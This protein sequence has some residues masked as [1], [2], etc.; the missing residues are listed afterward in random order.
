STRIKV[1]LIDDEFKVIAAG[2]SEWENELNAD[3]FWTYSENIIWSKLQEA[4][5]NLLANV[6]R[7]FECIPTGYGAVG[8]SAMMHGY[9][10]LDKSGKLLVPFRTWRNGNTDQATKELSKLFNFNIPHRWSIAHLHQAILNKESHLTEIDQ[11][12]T[13]AG[14]VHWKLTGEKVLGVGDASGM[15]PIDSK[16]NQYNQEMIDQYNDLV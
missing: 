16:T 2:E 12:T 15:F 14:Y 13:L 7:E 8:F 4:Y 5:A 10:A 3:G 9:I 1:V 11:I 6:K